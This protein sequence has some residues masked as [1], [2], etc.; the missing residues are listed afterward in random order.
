M[1]Y[2]GP[3]PPSGT[4][5]RMFCAGSLMSQALQCRQFCALMRSRSRAPSSAAYSYTPAAA[6]MSV[7]HPA[8]RVMLSPR[9]HACQCSKLAG[10]DIHDQRPMQV[11]QPRLQ[12]LRHA[13]ATAS[14]GGKGKAHGHWCTCWAV[15]ALR[16]GVYGPVD[17]V[18]DARVAQA[19]VGRLVVVVVGA[20]AGKEHSEQDIEEDVPYSTPMPGK[21]ASGGRVAGKPWQELRRGRPALAGAQTA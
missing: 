2:A 9:K 17:D 13:G 1:V 15:A 6:A 5:Q 20:A 3:P 12:Q 10:W 21:L 7:Q 4:L 18:G 16:A 14:R 8:R 19:Q 11:E